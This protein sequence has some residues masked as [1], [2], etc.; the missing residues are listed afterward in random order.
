MTM[1]LVSLFTE[2]H[3]PDG[4]LH[5]QL[6]SMD[7]DS[8]DRLVEEQGEESPVAQI[9]RCKRADAYSRVS[10]DLEGIEG[11]LQQEIKNAKIEGNLF[12]QTICYHIDRLGYKS[13]ADF[14]NSINMLRQQFSRRRYASHTLSKK[15]VLWIIVA[16]RLDYE[17]ACDLLQKAGYRFRKGDMRDVILMYIFRNTTYDL[18]EVNQVLEHFGIAPLG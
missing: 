8:L 18:Y 6:E 14:Y 2:A 5:N 15:T 13:D 11:A 9:I 7:E 10:C 1:D 4:L 3:K 12:Y 17:Q 16:L